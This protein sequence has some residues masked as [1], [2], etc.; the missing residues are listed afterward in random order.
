M[1][2]CLSGRGFCQGPASTGHR[3]LDCQKAA[4]APRPVGGPA[5]I[6]NATIRP[7]ITPAAVPA[8]VSPAAPPPR[9]GTP[10]PVG[11]PGATGRPAPVTPPATVAPAGGS[12]APRVVYRG[13]S[14]LLT[15]LPRGFEARVPLEL[16]A[17]RDFIRLYTGVK[18]LKDCAFAED[19][20]KRR[21]TLE[22]DSPT[23]VHTP[24]DLVRL[25]I[26]SRIPGPAVSTDPDVACGGYASGRQIYRID[27]SHLRVVPW[28]EAVP[29][30]AQR[31]TS[32][33]PQLLLNRD[34]RSLD[35]ATTIAVWNVKGGDTREVMF[36]TPIPRDTIATHTSATAA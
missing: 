7:A 21:I 5:S 20:R 17:A 32:F 24:V 27:T 1:T 6:T 34:A 18:Q 26:A 28:S 33:W 16:E 9:A 35:D 15:D 22:S 23:A 8:A 13:D 3:C 25:I 11:G 10:A 2:A 14:R 12:D 30:M 29:G 31:Q 4:L 36:L 19:V